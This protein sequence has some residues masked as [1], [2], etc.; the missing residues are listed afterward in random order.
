VISPSETFSPGVRGGRPLRV[1]VVSGESRSTMGGLSAYARM[2]VRQLQSRG[3]NVT[4]VARF[5]RPEAGP[6]DYAAPS[7]GVGSPIDGIPTNL[8]GPSPRWTP[9]LRRLHHMT[10]RRALRRFPPKIFARAF[11]Q[12]LARAIPQ[13]CDLVH[14]IGAG[15]ELL[16]FA[17]L[18]VARSRGAA[19]SILPAVHCQTWGDSPLD[20]DLYEQSDA[21]FCQS[22][23][24]MNHLESLGVS[25][26]RLVRVWLAPV[27]SPAGNG[28]TFRNAHGIANRPL[29]LFIGRRMRAK[30]F[31]A[32]CEAMPNIIQKVPN[33]LLVAIGPGGEP[34]YPKVYP[35][36]YLDLGAASE[37]TKADALAACD[38]FC[39]PSATEAFG[40]VYVEAWSYGKAVVGGPA[41]AVRELITDGEN[42]YCA[43]QNVN[44]IAG[45]LSKLLKDE[46]L[47]I[48]LGRA[49]HE[50]QST[51]YSWP[52]VTQLHMD[53][54][55]SITSYRATSLAPSCAY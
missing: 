34:P 13:D 4:T 8:V 42:G 48:R 50:L 10:D 28:C 25:R 37:L 26:S 5:E 43:E 3:V 29:I 40:I 30:G 23:H 47:R 22:Q 45:V 46:P 19:F 15:R 2:L 14:Y 11:A 27:A 39:M 31:H 51:R 16:G 21:V 35:E 36:S 20:I 52:A 24:E 54:F 12:S 55:H 6:M 44:S 33:V 38:V 41:P 7:S 32:L 9:I 1:C 53:I 49:G 18:A 17:A